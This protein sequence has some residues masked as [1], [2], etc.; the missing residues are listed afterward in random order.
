ME[1]LPWVFL[2]KRESLFIIVS[3]VLPAE[4]VVGESSDVSDERLG[5]AAGARSQ[6]RH[7]SHRPHG[8]VRPES[9]LK[10]KQKKNN[11]H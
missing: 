2:E 4:M 6:A 11:A 3:C 10:K 1:K 9:E 5:D 7:R 8:H